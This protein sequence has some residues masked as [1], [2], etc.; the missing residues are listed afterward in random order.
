MASRLYVAGNKVEPVC[1]F[2]VVVVTFTLISDHASINSVKSIVSLNVALKSNIFRSTSKLPQLILASIYHF[3]LLVLSVQLVDRVFLMEMNLFASCTETE[4][5]LNNKRLIQTKLVITC[6]S[7]QLGASW[8]TALSDFLLC[9]SAVLS[10]PTL[11]SPSLYLTHWQ[12]CWRHLL[13]SVLSLK[14]RCNEPV[15]RSL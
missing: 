2:G 1:V 5:G 11:L 15:L 8:R 4:I 7:W 10:F 3:I 14:G 6:C 13:K 12:S 9:S